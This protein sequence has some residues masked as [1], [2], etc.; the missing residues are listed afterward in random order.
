MLVTEITSPEVR[1]MRLAKMWGRW[2][3]DPADGVSF[4]GIIYVVGLVVV[5][6][7]IHLLQPEREGSGSSSRSPIHQEGPR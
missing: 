5:L 6:L 4:V 7:L 3:P 1:K 2:R